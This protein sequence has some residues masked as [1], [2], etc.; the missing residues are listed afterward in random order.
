MSKI[1]RGIRNNNPLNIRRGSI[2]KG[3]QPQQTDKAF[4]Q[5]VSMEYGVRAALYL[6]RV[7]VNKHNL[8]SVNEII[9]RWAPPEDHN[10]TANYIRIVENALENE[11]LVPIWGGG[12]IY[13]ETFKDNVWWFTIL[14]AMAKHECGYNLTWDVYEWAVALL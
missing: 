12:Y 6:M 10:N 13:K 9:T 14:K 4:C 2:W 8:H 3:L 5:F 7:Y 1:S 11:G